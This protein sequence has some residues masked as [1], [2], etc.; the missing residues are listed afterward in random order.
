MDSEA[1]RDLVT[2]ASYGE[3]IVD[4]GSEIKC[5]SMNVEPIDYNVD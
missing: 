1:V 2:T 4:S 3:G 5:Y